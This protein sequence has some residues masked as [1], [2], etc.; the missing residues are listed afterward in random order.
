MQSAVER[1]Q[2]TTVTQPF[3]HQ[4]VLLEEVLEFLAPR[5]GG[6]YVDGTLG[7]AG[8]AEN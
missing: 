4:P 7:G 5:P 1:A 8:H 6:T 2:E 3:A